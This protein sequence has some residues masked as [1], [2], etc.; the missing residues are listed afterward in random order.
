MAL[1]SYVDILEVVG[2]LADFKAK[3][4]EGEEIAQNGGVIKL[5][6]KDGKTNGAHDISASCYSVEDKQS[7]FNVSISVVIEPRSLQCKCSCLD[8][9]SDKCEHVV[10]TLIHIH[11]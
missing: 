5:R 3:L 2:E 11:R 8:E 4:K 10:A 9:K 7:L 1:I 6:I